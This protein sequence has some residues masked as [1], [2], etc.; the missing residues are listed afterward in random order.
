M[1]LQPVTLTQYLYMDDSKTSQI[2]P[3]NLIISA[4]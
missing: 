3:T 1:N 2:I 4:L